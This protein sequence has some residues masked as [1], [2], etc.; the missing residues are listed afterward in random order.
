MGGRNETALVRGIGISYALHNGPCVRGGA[1]VLEGKVWS[2]TLI[3]VKPGMLDS[4]LRD[5]IPKRR[6]YVE[7]AKA[8]DSLV[9]SHIV[10]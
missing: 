6:E 7:K 1:S 2:V 8:A 10:V 9:R 3:R 5:I 4:Y